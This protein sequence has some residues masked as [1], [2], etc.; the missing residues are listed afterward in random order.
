MSKKFNKIRNT[1]YDPLLHNATNHLKM[2]HIHTYYNF[3]GFCKNC[4]NVYRIINT[5]VKNIFFLFHVFLFNRLSFFFKCIKFLENIKY[6][7]VII[8]FKRNAINTQKKYGHL[9]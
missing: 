6:I 2:Y 7:E 8:Q 5:L 9:W 3:L 1:F 4:L